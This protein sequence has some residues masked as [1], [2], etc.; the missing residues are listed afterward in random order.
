MQGISD[1]NKNSC[2]E[3]TVIPQSILRTMGDSDDQEASQKLEK[4]REQN[5]DASVSSDDYSSSNE[6]NAVETAASSTA[7]N[8]AQKENEA[9]NRSK[10]LVY[11]VLII[12]AVAVGLTTYLFTSNTEEDD[13]RNTVRHLRSCIFVSS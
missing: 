4:T 11:V 3:Y 5:D 8:I 13:F 7:D 10:C 9:L 1:T 12:A 2:A 6:S